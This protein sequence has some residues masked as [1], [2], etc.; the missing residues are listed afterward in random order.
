VLTVGTLSSTAVEIDF[1]VLAVIPGELLTVTA[2]YIGST[3]NM[4]TTLNNANLIGLDPTLF[5]VATAKNSASAEVGLN[6]AGRMVLY[7]N[8]AAGN[9]TRLTINIASGFTIKAVEIVFGASTNSATTKVTL[10]TE[11]VN[12]TSAQS[13]N[14]T[15][16][17]LDKNVSSL[18]LQNTQ[19]GGSAGQV[20]ILSIKITYQQVIA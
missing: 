14:S 11:E 1:T 3:V 7:A 16:T 5:T 8:V 9:G 10:G 20:F 4:S 13:L 19:V 2:A 17:Y 6:S 18:S 12:L 15:Q